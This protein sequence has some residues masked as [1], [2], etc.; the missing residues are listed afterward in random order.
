MLAFLQSSGTVPMLSDFMKIFVITGASSSA[1]VLRMNVGMVSGP[2]ALYGFKFFSSLMIPGIV[3]TILSI[4]V[5]G[6][7]S[8][9]GKWS[10]FSLV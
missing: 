5:Y 9:S 4:V 8:F 7:V 3:T 1:A 10:V 6:L 2:A